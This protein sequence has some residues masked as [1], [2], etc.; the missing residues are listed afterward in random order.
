MNSN[1]DTPKIDF[2]AKYLRY[3]A[4][5]NL[6]G[7]DIIAEKNGKETH[8]LTLKRL[9]TADKVLVVPDFI[10]RMEYMALERCGPFEEI[11]GHNHLL[12][13]AELRGTGVETLSIDLPTSCRV[14]PSIRNYS[15]VN[16]KINSKARL[17]KPINNIGNLKIENSWS[18]TYFDRMCLCK[19]ILN[20]LY[21]KSNS[22]SRESIVRCN[23]EDMH[24]EYPQSKRA[25]FGNSIGTVHIYISSQEK[26]Q[27][28]KDYGENYKNKLFERCGILGQTHYR[29]VEIHDSLEFPEINMEES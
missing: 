21:V 2:W 19:D 20:E 4:K 27:L 22:A 23:I 9:V 5:L 16:I 28:E 15:T 14:I 8:R 25:L 29:K 1:S 7:G 11:I 17:T 6:L 10:S 24:L 12:N 3:K 18:I 26:A 13:I